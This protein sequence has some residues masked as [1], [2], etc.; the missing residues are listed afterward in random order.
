MDPYELLNLPRGATK[1][2]IKKSFRS[3]ARASHPDK[4]GR[5]EDFS[6]FQTAYELLADDRR[7]EIFDRTGRGEA[8]PLELFEEEFKRGRQTAEKKTPSSSILQR[9]DA[10]RPSAGLHSR[11]FEE[12]MR[13]ANVANV[14]SGGKGRGREE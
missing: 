6:K 3:L 11:G 14:V 12:W 9:L 4:G 1:T 5:L 7:R 2:A 10:P 8:S 13:S